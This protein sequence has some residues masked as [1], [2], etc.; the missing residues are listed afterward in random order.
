VAL[1][2]LHVRYIL[3][4]AA[5]VVTEMQVGGNTQLDAAEQD[6]RYCW[7]TS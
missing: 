2:L 4:C 3:L 7:S 6:A 5:G 1:R